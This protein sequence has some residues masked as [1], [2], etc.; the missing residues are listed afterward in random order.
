M[1][2][3]G[4]GAGTE[5]AAALEGETGAVEPGVET[6]AV[7]YTLFFKCVLCQSGAKNGVYWDADKGE[8]KVARAVAVRRTG[9]MKHESCTKKH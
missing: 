1:A 2:G 4:A 8:R 9:S 3:D 6:G 5:V 7:G